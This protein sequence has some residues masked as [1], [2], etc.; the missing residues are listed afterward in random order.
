MA[1]L[2]QK[3]QSILNTARKAANTEW[4][5][6]AIEATEL[7]QFKVPEGFLW[8]TASCE[9]QHSG[10][11]NCSHNNWA[12]W[13]EKKIGG[14]KTSIKNGQKSGPSNDH[15]NRYKDDIQLMKELG[16]N[17]YRFSLDWGEIE[18]EEGVFNQTAIAHYQD[19]CDELKKHSITPMV[20]LLHFTYPHWLELKGGFEKEENIEYFVRFSKHMF[21]A[22]QEKVKLWCIINELP[23]V[24]LMGYILGDFPPGKRD[25]K[26]AGFVL[27]NLLKAHCTVYQ[28]LKSLPGGDQA[29]LGIV[30]SSIKFTPRHWWN[31]I[32]VLV[33]FYFNHIKNNKFINFF[34][35][36][37][38]EWLTSWGKKIKYFNKNAPKCFDFFG[39]NYYSR[40]VVG[41]KG[42]FS[43]SLFPTCFSGEIMT[44]MPYAIYPEGLY[45]AIKEAAEFGVPIYITENGIADCHD[46][47]RELF[48]K[49][50]L[51]VMGKAINAGYDV[52]GYF[53]WSLTDNFE[54]TD[55]Y[56]MHF[57]LY[58]VN[59]LTQERTLRKG[60]ACYKT[61]IENT[62]SLLKFENET[63]IA[64]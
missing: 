32:E 17:S 25:L 1:F 38:F 51:Y 58:K 41:S 50:H 29:Q 4:N 57:G 3:T 53:Y 11:E 27:K 7:D 26:L 56:S 64:S 34:K 13:E 45:Y 60:S 44:D 46:D 63:D 54:W 59:F 15:W 16:V 48:I 31:I 55:G 43:L 2:K 21:I 62:V 6:H 52:R 33:S 8:G 19:L 10:A 42:F 20:T 35:Y 18:P 5:W 22:L 30:H 24:V 9:Y 12:A 28:T 49:R 61:I 14:K 47:R 23:I 40:I 39:L 36:G 37:T